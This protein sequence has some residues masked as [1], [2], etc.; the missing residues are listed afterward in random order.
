MKPIVNVPETNSHEMI[1]SRIETAPKTR[2]A[3]SDMLLLKSFFALLLV[4][5]ALSCS[6]SKEE[7]VSNPKDKSTTSDKNVSSEPPAPVVI[8]R[9]TQQ[10][11]EPGY[12]AKQFTAVANGIRD[13]SI[14]AK[15]PGRIVAIDVS[16]GE[17]VEVGQTLIRLDSVL[18]RLAVDAALAGKESAEAGRSKAERD[19]KRAEEL[20]AES[21]ISQSRLESVRLAFQVANA[22]YDGAVA[23][24]GASKRQLA[25]TRIV[26]PFAGEVAR[27]P[28]EL[29]ETP[30]PGGIVA[31]VTD[32]SELVAEI[33]LSEEEAQV[34]SVGSKARVTIAGDAQRGRDG[35]LRALSPK[36]NEVT[37]LFKGEVVIENRD[38]LL[39]AGVTCRVRFAAEMTESP[40]VPLDAIVEVEGE[41]GSSFVVVVA[42][43]DDGTSE[44]KVSRASLRRVTLGQ[45]IGSGVS[46][47][48][49]LDFGERI[50][51]K[52][53]QSLSDNQPVRMLK[54]VSLDSLLN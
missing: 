54:E 25:E 52:G 46:I 47:V 14:D 4:V 33:F 43:L 7:P 45:R 17:A 32:R 49:G 26:A 20:F 50:V 2:R 5:G 30:L 36:G 9:V 3:F 39:R 15:R 23:E 31:E 42:D 35:V 53:A 51:V 16:L 37:K 44:S 10:A 8:S 40:I 48:S 12:G 28:Y 38:L 6:S 34:I 19:L 22:T 29:G 13:A 24:L 41:V 11:G 21:G 27:L 1:E 18:D